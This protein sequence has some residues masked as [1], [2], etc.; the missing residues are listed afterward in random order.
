[1]APMA[2]LLQPAW[3]LYARVLDPSKG[4]LESPCQLH[5][6]HRGHCARLEAAEGNLKKLHN[7]NKSRSVIS[8]QWEGFTVILACPWD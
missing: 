6:G 2:R 8:R 5:V 7:P 1:M 4:L 3:G